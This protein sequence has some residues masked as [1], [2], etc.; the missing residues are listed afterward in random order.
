MEPLC[1][2]VVDSLVH[3]WTALHKDAPVALAA[4]E[5][6]YLRR[7]ILH[8]DDELLARLLGAKLASSRTTRVGPGCDFARLGS[9]I[10]YSVK[11]QQHCARL[12]HGEICDE[13]MLGVGSRFG[14]ALI[15]FRAGQTV[16]W[17]LQQGRLVELKILRAEPP[18]PMPRAAIAV[19]DR[20][21]LCESG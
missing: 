6:H 12:V 15:G 1:H 3:I 14:S 13:N 9:K 19:M 18:R 16:L 21:P 7:L 20:R 17:P 5:A 2:S 4:P 11:G 8:M 10:L